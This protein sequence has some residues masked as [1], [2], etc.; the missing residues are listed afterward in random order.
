[1]ELSSAPPETK[2]RKHVRIQSVGASKAAY[3]WGFPPKDPEKLQK[4]ESIE[5][6][7]QQAYGPIYQLDVE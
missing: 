2:W 3:S 4:Q 6:G 7:L 5:A 1:V